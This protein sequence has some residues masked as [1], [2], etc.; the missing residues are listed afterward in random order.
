VAYAVCYL[1]SESTKT[2]LLLR[3]GSDDE[4]KVFLNGKEIYRWEKDRG[5][6]PDQDVVRN[7]ELKAGTNILVFKVVNETADWRGSLRL[8]DTEGRPVKGLQV[9][10]TP[11]EPGPPP[12]VGPD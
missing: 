6:V 1:L 11:P 5:Y 3:V 12:P 9:T 10:L 8:S 7:V 4:A 2:N